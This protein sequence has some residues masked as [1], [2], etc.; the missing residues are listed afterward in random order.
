MKLKSILLAVVAVAVTAGVHAADTYTKGYVKK[1]GTYVQGH[2]KTK[3]NDT[4]LDNYSTKGNTNPYTGKKG[5]KD[6]NSK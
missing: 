4:K 3:A 6:P 2:Y 5:T 1:D